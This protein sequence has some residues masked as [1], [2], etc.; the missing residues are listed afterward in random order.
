MD[1]I[2][3]TAARTTAAKN[4]VIKLQAS[5]SDESYT[6]F[7][8]IMSR[9][10]KRQ[11]TKRGLIA[12]VDDLFSDLDRPD[13]IG[14]FE[15]FLPIGVT[16]D[17]IREGNSKCSTYSADTTT[18]RKHE[19]MVTSV[20][21]PAA[22]P[23]SIGPVHT[24]DIPAVP[25]TPTPTP[26]V[27]TVELALSVSSSLTTKVAVAS[28]IESI[29]A[30]EEQEEHS[31]PSAVPKT[32]HAEQLEDFTYRLQMRFLELDTPEKYQ[33]FLSLMAESK[34]SP[35]S[36]PAAI[37]Q[38]TQLLRDQPDLLADFKRVIASISFAGLL[39]TPAVE[40]TNISTTAAARNSR[41]RKSQS[42][43]SWNASWL[44]ADVNASLSGAHAPVGNSTVSEEPL[45]EGTVSGFEPDQY[46]TAR[47]VL[48]Q[49]EN[50][51]L[52]PAVAPR[53]ISG[54]YSKGRPVSMIVGAS[55]SHTLL[56]VPPTD[57]RTPLLMTYEDWCL[58]H[59]RRSGTVGS[60]SAS[61]SGSGARSK[62]WKR[63]RWVGGVFMAGAL[64]FIGYAMVL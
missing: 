33:K 17:M 47:S 58:E 53:R 20:L 8:G 15:V 13:L 42:M 28:P 5:L 63:W 34:V 61:T 59:S 39:T 51:E 21:A 46:R 50:M 18:A 1:R 38:A 10:K 52:G 16:V 24:A 12:E 36:Y 6:K 32:S 9:Y 64:A 29:E 44:P 40:R 7:L 62:W 43:G 22:E 37:Y 55:R 41:H 14:G 26:T 60:N 3:T 48:G 27:N 2:S 57:E 54:G 4:Y 25:A 45:P 49:Q 11:L 23:M 31:Q 35:S 30:E 56:D 19:S